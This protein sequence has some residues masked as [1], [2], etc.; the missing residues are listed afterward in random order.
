MISVDLEEREDLEV[1]RS[2]DDISRLR[3]DLISYPR[4]FYVGIGWCEQPRKD[5]MFALIV[6]LFTI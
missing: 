2:R 3:V 6:Y 4:N 5:A 1:E